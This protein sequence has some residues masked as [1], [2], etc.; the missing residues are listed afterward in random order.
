MKLRGRARRSARAA[1]ATSNENQLIDG[2]SLLPLFAG[3]KHLSRDALYWHYPM[4]KPHF[5]GGT[6]SSAIRSGDWKLIE[7]LDTGK[8]ELYDLAHDLSESHDLSTEQ[9]KR[10]QKLR[11]KL[12]DWKRDVKAE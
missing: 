12:D 9:P 4:E 2:T 3:K 10:A 7:F 8:V 1:S 6:S 5:L 11:K